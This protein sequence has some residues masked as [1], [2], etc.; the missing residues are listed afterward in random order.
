MVPLLGRGRTIRG[1]RILRSFIS[2]AFAAIGLA[3]AGPACAQVL[4]I[5]DDGAVTTYVGPQV[6]SSEGVRSLLPQTTPARAAP[7]D[8]TRAIQDASVR[9]S[10]STPLVA[11]VAW[12]ESRYNQAAGLAWTPLT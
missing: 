12:Q 3:L 1:I 6:Y 7:E 11:A 9:H 10:V 8:V 4:S 2:V 5:G